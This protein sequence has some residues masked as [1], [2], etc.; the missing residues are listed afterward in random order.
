MD[1]HLP[2][3]MVTGWAA[4]LE[5]VVPPLREGL[6]KEGSVFDPAHVLDFH[7]NSRASACAVVSQGCPVVQCSDCACHM[8]VPQW[9]V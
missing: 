5:L 1:K 3:G 8:A 7:G 2:I 9:P 6:K 4:P